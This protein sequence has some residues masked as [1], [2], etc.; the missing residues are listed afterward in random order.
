MLKDSTKRKR[1]RE[2]LK[3]VA[4]EEEKLKQNKQGYLKENKRLRTE[5]DNLSQ[6]VIKLR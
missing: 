4:D 2:E 5:K 3:E 1:T 6:E